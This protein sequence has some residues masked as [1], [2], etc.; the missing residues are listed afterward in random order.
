M[1]SNALSRPRVKLACR[2]SAGTMV[3]RTYDEE[4]L[5]SPELIA[6][7]AKKYERIIADEVTYCESHT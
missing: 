7:T 3:L 6:K 4:T 1:H 2:K 5:L